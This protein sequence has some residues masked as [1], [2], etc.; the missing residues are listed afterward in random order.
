M[1]STGVIRKVDPL[2]RVVIPMELRRNLDIK[3]NDPMEIY[4]DGETIMIKK[5]KVGCFRCGEMNGVREVEGL[6]ICPKCIEFFK[7]L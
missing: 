7:Q 5:H 1:K 2:G 4:V 6:K 3:E